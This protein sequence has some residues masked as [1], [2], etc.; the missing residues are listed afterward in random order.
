M[1]CSCLATQ[2]EWGGGGVGVMGGDGH[3]SRVKQLKSDRGSMGKCTVHTHTQV[4]GI[5]Q[6]TPAG[7]FSKEN[8]RRKINGYVVT[9]HSI[10]D[11][12]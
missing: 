7:T 11:H 12:M 8:P 9:N 6:W 10:I 1:E 2:G 3:C 4:T 5:E